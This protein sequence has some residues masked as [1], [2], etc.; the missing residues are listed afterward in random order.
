MTAPPPWAAVIGSPVG[1]SLSPVLHLAAYAELG[2][3][4]SYTA[5]ECPEPAL[6]GQLASVRRDTGWRGFSVTMPLKL[7]ALGLVDRPTARAAAVGAVNTVLP[8]ADDLVGDNTDLPGMVA[9]A[10]RARGRRLRGDRSC[11]VRAARRAP[12]S[13]PSPSSAR[14]RPWS[15]SGRPAG[16]ARWSTWPPGSA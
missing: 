9:T 2:L 7:A 12:R 4:W 3:D 13:V 5:V 1:H 14:Q 8:D 15:W 10:A 6:A 16:P 11:L